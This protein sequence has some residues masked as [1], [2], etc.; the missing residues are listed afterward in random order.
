MLNLMHKEFGIGSLIRRGTDVTTTW[1][2][3]CDLRRL[4]PWPGFADTKRPITQFGTIWVT[5]R[6]GQDVDEHRHD[7]EECFIV[8]SGKADLKL[9]GHVTTLGAGDVVY[10]PRFW[11]HQIR[12]PYGESFQF[13]DLYWDDRGRS[14]NEY[15]AQL[16]DGDLG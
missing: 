7:E 9:E 6:A 2:Y 15:Q 16:S 5:V 12:N 14:F 11:M 3:N 4:L 1:E 13:I 10:I 8:L